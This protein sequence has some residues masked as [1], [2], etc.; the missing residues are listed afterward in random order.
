M[1]AKRDRIPVEL[2]GRGRLLVVAHSHFSEISIRLLRLTWV[3]VA[4]NSC[5]GGDASIYR[6]PCVTEL[7]RRW[8]DGFCGLVAKNW[9]CSKVGMAMLIAATSA[10]GKQ[11]RLFM[12]NVFMCIISQDL[13]GHLVASLYQ[14][15]HLAGPSWPRI[16]YL[17]YESCKM[18]GRWSLTRLPS[19]ESLFHT[20]FFNVYSPWLL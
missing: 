6:W 1:S 5:S 14:R 9:I 12:W 20:T 13:L 3:I 18:L 8:S 19:S 17:S 4:G 2:V 15:G 7:E 11:M 10:A 16:F